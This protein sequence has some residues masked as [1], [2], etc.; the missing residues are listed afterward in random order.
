M[1]DTSL[2]ATIDRLQ[3]ELQAEIDTRRRLEALDALLPALAGVLDI[4]EVFE[5]VSRIARQVIPHD[6]TS[7]VLLTEDREHIT[8]HAIAGDNAGFPKMVPLRGHHRPLV[9]SPWDHLIQAD[10]QADAVERET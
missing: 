7:V 8:I 9:T 1:D 5:G 4:R 2:R 3:R 6:L 10:I